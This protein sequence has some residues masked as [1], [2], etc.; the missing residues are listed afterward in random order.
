MAGLAGI[1]S[2]VQA[3]P[4]F[5][6]GLDMI[7]G[8]A[9]EK[10][11]LLRI[12]EAKGQ[13]QQQQMQNEAAKL[14]Q[15]ASARAMLSEALA[16]GRITE[17]DIAQ[18]AAVDPE[19]GM[20]LLKMMREGAVKP[21]STQAKIQADIEA[22]LLTPEQGADALAKAN[23]MR[24][25]D[26]VTVNNAQE[27]EYEKG[28]GKGLAERRLQIL[29][30]GTAAEGNIAGYQELGSLLDQTYT[31]AGGEAL[32][33]LATV[34]NSLGIDTSDIG[35]DADAG[36]AARALSRKM[37]L[38]LRNPAGG[39]GMPGAMSD[40]DR[41][42]LVSMVPGLSSTPEGA[43]LILNSRIRVEQ[44]NKQVADLAAAYEER[45]GR[46]DSGFF[47]K[48]AQ[49]SS[50]NPLFSDEERAAMKAA[51]KK[52]DKGGTQTPN[53]VPAGV[54]EAEWNAMTA[55]ERALWK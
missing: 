55:E 10:D 38:E 7:A 45:F 53:A 32:Q 28:V 37:A 39:A 24:P 35:L 47:K 12:E 2:G 41:Q 19:A 49:W 36:Q 9:G 44:R 33:E 5:Q 22:G 18:V 3:D 14:Q 26:S 8:P 21:Q 40:Q 48:L 11:R 13:M 1:L 6:Q 31:G 52:S 25:A 23:Y 51:G 46:I 34:A 17:E 16:D 50:Q 54:S 43:R 27:R 15:Q 4:R 30:S 29:D 20:G 42:F